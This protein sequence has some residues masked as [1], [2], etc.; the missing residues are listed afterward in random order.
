MFRCASRSRR[1][2]VITRSFHW[3]TAD[4]MNCDVKGNPA[5]SSIT[6]KVPIIIGNLDETYV[7]IDPQVGRA[8]Y[9]SFDAAS[10]SVPSDICKLTF[11]HDSQHFGSEVSSYPRLHIPRNFPRQTDSNTSPATLFLTGK[12]YEIVLDG[13]PDAQFAEKASATGRDLEH[14]LDQLKDM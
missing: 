13:T 3:V 2:A 14:V 12:M 7:L 10:T 9:T 4:F 5:S 11:F 8:L 6:T 1:I